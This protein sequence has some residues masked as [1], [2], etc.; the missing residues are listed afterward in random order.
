[1][2]ALSLGMKFLTNTYLRTRNKDLGVVQRWMGLLIGV[3][4]YPMAAQWV[5][6]YFASPEGEAHLQPLLLECP[7]KTVR[8]QIRYANILCN[9]PD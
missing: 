3:L 6:E 1:M 9:I 8:L 7:E 4:N 2:N 5:V